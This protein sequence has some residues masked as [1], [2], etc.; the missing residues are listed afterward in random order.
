[1]FYFNVFSDTP[2]LRFRPEDG[3]R[4]RILSVILVFRHVQRI[5]FK[6]GYNWIQYI[7]DNISHPRSKRVHSITP[8]HTFPTLAPSY[9]LCTSGMS[10]LCQKWA[11]LA[12]MVLFLDFLKNL[13]SVN[14]VSL[15]WQMS[16]V[17]HI[18]CRLWNLCRQ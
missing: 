12:Q 10:N 17:G 14:F 4:E 5:G 11:K 16:R 1:M 7:I 6:T 2:L 9:P 13:I 8:F 18:L 3:K 15:S